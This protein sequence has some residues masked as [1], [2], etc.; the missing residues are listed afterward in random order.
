MDV[1]I[2][3]HGAQCSFMVIE[4][5]WPAILHR[6]V[7]HLCIQRKDRKRKGRA[8]S[9]IGRL[10]NDGYESCW[11]EINGWEIEQREVSIKDKMWRFD[12]QTPPP[13]TPW[14][15]LSKKIGVVSKQ[16]AEILNLHDIW[17]HILCPKRTC[18]PKHYIKIIC[19]NS[20]VKQK[21]QWGLKRRG[22]VIG[23]K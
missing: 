6:P 9:K 10:G 5:N 21:Q 7:N 1:S 16:K 18:S 15:T 4:G 13:P 2:I 23:W 17:Q 8:E 22:K 3:T 12:W 14:Q 11:Q 19:C 20:A